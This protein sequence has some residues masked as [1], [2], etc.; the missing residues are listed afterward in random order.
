MILRASIL[1]FPW[2]GFPEREWLFVLPALVN[3][4][5]PP[6]A[7]SALPLAG[8]PAALKRDAVGSVGGF[9]GVC[10]ELAVTCRVSEVEV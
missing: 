10:V 2:I 3:P 5:P 6:A 7:S 4:L 8:F 1:G 9:G